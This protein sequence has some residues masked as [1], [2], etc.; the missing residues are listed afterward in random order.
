MF[1]GKNHYKWWFS[2]VMLNYQRVPYVPY[3][4]IKRWRICHTS[5]LL[6]AWNRQDTVSARSALRSFPDLPARSPRSLGL[7]TRPRGDLGQGVSSQGRL[8]TSSLVLVKSCQISILDAWIILDPQMF[9]V[10]IFNHCYIPKNLNIHVI[11]WPKFS[12]SIPI[13]LW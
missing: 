12:H 6:H 9:F 5:M 1:H 8:L 11:K 4:V 3:R 2:I 7:P 13:T 10:F